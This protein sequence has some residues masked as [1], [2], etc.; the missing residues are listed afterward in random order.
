MDHLL[1]ADCCLPVQF[2]S[3]Q[4]SSALANL[5]KLQL[6]SACAVEI[7]TNMN[8]LLEYNSQVTDDDRTQTH[9]YS[10]SVCGPSCR[11]SK[12][13]TL[14]IELFP[15]IIG[16]GCGPRHVNLHIELEVGMRSSVARRFPWSSSSKVSTSIAWTLRYDRVSRFRMTTSDGVPVTIV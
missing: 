11:N 2:S 15:S 7:H 8:C 5:R 14:P 16:D 4:F 3:V 1:T 10:S 6:P 9:L 12:L 13:N